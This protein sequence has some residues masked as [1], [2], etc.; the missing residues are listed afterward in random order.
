[1][2]GYGAGMLL[3]ALGR[4]GVRAQLRH[5]DLAQVHGKAR[6]RR[7]CVCGRVVEL[8]AVWAARLGVV[9]DVLVE[10]FAQR[11]CVYFWGN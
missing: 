11:A 6:G 3:L 2:R 9:Y 4:Y 7:V 1:M 5:R 10:L 8:D